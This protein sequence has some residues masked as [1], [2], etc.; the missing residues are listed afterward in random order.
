M[1]TLLVII[2]L[3]AVV[4][5]VYGVFIAK[6]KYT[7][8]YLRSG[9]IYFGKVVHFPHYGLEQPYLLTITKDGQPSLQ[10]FNKVVWQPDDFISINRDE[11]IWSTTLREDSQLVKTFTENPDLLAPQGSQQQSG[12][13]PATQAQPKADS[14]ADAKDDTKQ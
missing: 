8:V 5:I 12:Q 2:V 14:K 6:P 4:G 10:R 13:A 9:D 11:V 3:A 1:I 7:A